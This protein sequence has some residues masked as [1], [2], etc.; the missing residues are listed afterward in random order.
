MFANE[1]P[2]SSQ[3]IRKRI[4][5]LGWESDEKQVIG[6]NQEAGGCP[7]KSEGF[8]RGQISPVVKRG[9]PISKNPTLEKRRADG[10]R[11]RG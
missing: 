10:K 11:G 2:R 6:G 7:M 4:N 5:V 3:H 9:E 8:L 1:E